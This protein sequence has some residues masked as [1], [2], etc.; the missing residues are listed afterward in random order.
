MQSDQPSTELERESDEQSAWQ[1]R[2]IEAA[3]R[4]ADAGDFA[5]D[6]EVVA[7]AGRWSA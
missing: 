5:D 1:L 7:F 2:E 6:A 4:E 3:L